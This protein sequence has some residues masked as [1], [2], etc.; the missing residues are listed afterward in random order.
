M[1]HHDEVVLVF[2]GEDGAL[3]LAHD[4]IVYPRARPLQQ[5]SYMSANYDPMIYPLLFPCGDPGWH[6][7][8][9]H[10]GKY[11]TEKRNRVST[12]HTDWP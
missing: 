4:I 8:L 3:P 11:S 5:I 7:G 2:V 12:T 1:P 9:A 6:C 10:V